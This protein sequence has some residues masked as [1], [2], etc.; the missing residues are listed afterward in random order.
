MVFMWQRGRPISALT[1]VSIDAVFSMLGRDAAA[2][3]TEFS[4]TRTQGGRKVFRIES[5]RVADFLN[6]VHSLEGVSATLYDEEGE[7]YVTSDKA[8]YDVRSGNL[9]LL[10]NVTLRDDQGLEAQTEEIRYDNEKKTASTT[11]PVRFRKSTLQG[12]GQRLHYRVADGMLILEGRVEADARQEDVPP[13]EATRI[14]LQA[15]RLEYDRARNRVV[16]RGAAAP[17]DNGEDEEA[18]KR[19]CVFLESLPSEA[20]ATHYRVWAPLMTAYF[21]GEVLDRIAARGDVQV[22]TQTR[23]PDDPLSTLRSERL[24]ARYDASSSRFSALE[25]SGHAAFQRENAVAYADQIRY[26]VE[27]DA[28]ELSGNAEAQSPSYILRSERMVFHQSEGRLEGQGTVQAVSRSP[29]PGQEDPLPTLRFP[30]QSEEPVYVYAD[31]VTM[32]QEEQHA[33]FRRSA[34]MRHGE[35]TISASV[36]HFYF[37]EG[38]LQ[39]DDHVLTRLLTVDDERA[40]TMVASQ[41]LRYED[42]ERV[43]VYRGG[44]QLMRRDVSLRSEDLYAYFSEGGQASE[45]RIE[46][47]MARGDVILE[48]PGRRGNGDWAEYLM[49]REEATLGGE[50]EIEVRELETGRVARGRV[51]TYSLKGDALGVYTDAHGRTVSTSQAAEPPPETEPTTTSAAADMESSREAAH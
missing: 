43:A 9:T 22:E 37:K 34:V 30:F 6:G 42:A 31:E 39:A 27:G 17:D 28:I 25:F 24:L 16:L 41:S 13:D 44:T 46:R 2:E 49:G 18:W 19:A 26:E 38:V 36:L 47:L 45:N 5:R 20:D 14:L 10:G 29:E 32:W 1:R 50:R 51:L 15:E 48:S 40:P 4:H 35:D 3:G 11:N 7:L 33:E 21:A 8:D 12:K 23:L